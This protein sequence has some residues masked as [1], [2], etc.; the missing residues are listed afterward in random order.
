MFLRKECVVSSIQDPLVKKLI[1]LWL[2]LDFVRCEVSFITLSLVL[3]WLQPLSSTYIYEKGV[4]RIHITAEIT[5]YNIT[6]MA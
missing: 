3:T 6:I 4:K 5:E 2:L 1:F